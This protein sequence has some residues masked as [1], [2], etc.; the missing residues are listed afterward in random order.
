MASWKL[1]CLTLLQLSLVLAVFAQNSKNYLCYY[2]HS[3]YQ[4]HSTFLQI[5]W[6][7]ITQLFQQVHYMS[8]EKGLHTVTG[9][10]KYH[11]PSL[12]LTEHVFERMDSLLELTQ[13]KKMIILTTRILEQGN[14][15]FGLDYLIKMWKELS[16]M[17]SSTLP[18]MLLKY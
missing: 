3:A 16:G 9:C 15:I 5:H 11:T 2:V 18:I 10:L 7:V 17:L 14:K 1:C 12:Q 6:F 4:F 13:E 8:L